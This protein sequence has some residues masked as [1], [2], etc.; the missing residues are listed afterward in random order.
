MGIAGRLKKYFVKGLA[1]LLPTMLTIFLFIWTYGF[2]KKNI[3]VY[4]NRGLVW[5]IQ[6]VSLFLPEW[7][8]F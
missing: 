6:R 5:V 3:S 8:A 4:I 7:N 1:V 2:I